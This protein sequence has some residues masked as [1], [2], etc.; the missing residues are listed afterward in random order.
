MDRND[1]VTAVRDLVERERE[2]ASLETDNGGCEP[3]YMVE[4]A[5]RVAEAWQRI[6]EM[7]GGVVVCGRGEG[8][9]VVAV[10]TLDVLRASS[11]IVIEDVTCGG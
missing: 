5:E 11:C 4:K 2:L 7:L 8:A 6:G 1:L 10:D 3:E 9:R